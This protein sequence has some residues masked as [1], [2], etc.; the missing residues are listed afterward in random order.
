MKNNNAYYPCSICGWNSPL[1][2]VITDNNGK[3]VCYC[4]IHN[5]NE[6]DDKKAEDYEK[7]RDKFHDDF[8]KSFENLDTDS[9]EDIQ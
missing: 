8:R 2:V 1:N 6:K 9:I 4:P 5:T 3:E 7:R